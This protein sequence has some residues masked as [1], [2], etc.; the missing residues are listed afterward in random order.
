MSVK[1]VTNRGLVWV[2]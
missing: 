1:S 2:G